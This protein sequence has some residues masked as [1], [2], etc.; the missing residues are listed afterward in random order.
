MREN[1]C[2]QGYDVKLLFSRQRVNLLFSKQRGKTL[3]SKQRGKTLVLRQRGKTIIFK[4]TRDNSGR[5]EPTQKFSL[6]LK[7]ILG[8]G[9]EMV[10]L[11]LKKSKSQ[12][13]L[14]HDF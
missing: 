4:A 5:G 10:L 8:M 1:S 12:G 13:A 9:G 2:F 14:G 6:G 11:N 7:L 3:V